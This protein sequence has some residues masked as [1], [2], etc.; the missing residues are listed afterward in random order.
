MLGEHLDAGPSVAIRGARMKTPW[1]GVVVARRA[2]ASAS[3]LATWRP[4]A[5]RST[6]EVDQP[7]VL[8]VEHDHPRAGAEDRAG[9]S[10]RIA[11]SS[12]YETDQPHDRG[13]LAARDDEPVEPV[14]LLGQADLDHLGAEARAARRVLAKCALNRE[15]T[16]ARPLLHTRILGTAHG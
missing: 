14:E 3:K 1:S 15:D 2:R 13:R 9:R 5:F 4:Y 8:A 16:D 10:A 12:P 11:S 6:V 7:E